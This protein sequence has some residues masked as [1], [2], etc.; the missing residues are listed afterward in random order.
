LRNTDISR[1]QQNC[2]AQR[3]FRR[4]NA[5]KQRC[6]AQPGQEAHGE[7]VPETIKALREENHSLRTRL[8]GMESQLS[9]MSMLMSEMAKDIIHTLDLP[10]AHEK[11]PQVCS[12]EAQ[13]HIGYEQP[14]LP[15][16]PTQ[17]AYQA[18]AGH[19]AIGAEASPETFISDFGGEH[20]I[21]SSHDH[22]IN[23]EG[24]CDSGKQPHQA[25]LPYHP[26]LPSTTQLPRIWSYDYQMGPEVYSQAMQAV[27]TSSFALDQAWLASNSPLS[28]HI[29]YIKCVLQQDL[30]NLS[31]SNCTDQPLTRSV[32]RFL[33]IISCTDTKLGN[34]RLSSKRYLC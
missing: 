21:V 28:D 33:S 15:K 13:R 32:D 3:A 34:T 18:L 26:S 16:S 22:D 7:S 14:E 30:L 9:R 29:W 20:G 25:L 24:S 8:I 19:A 11:S 27:E 4:R 31:A 5:E 17:V 6:Q 1:R 12:K 2:L 10:H 23:G